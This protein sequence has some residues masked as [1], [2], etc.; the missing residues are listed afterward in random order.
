MMS[1]AIAFRRFG[2]GILLG[3][4]LGLLYGFL[5]PLRRKRNG[6]WDL[7]FVLC[8]GWVY[9]YYGF[10]VCRADL[11]MGYFFAPIAGGLGWEWSFG[12][13]LRPFFAGFWEKTR[14]LARPFWK[15]FKKI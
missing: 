4:A 3:V 11:R 8:A 10:A 9:L 14:S 5:R 15:I 2:I 7:V 13:Y 1:P 12:R 6:F